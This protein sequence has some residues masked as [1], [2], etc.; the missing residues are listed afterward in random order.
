[1]YTIDASGF[2]TATEAHELD[3]AVSRQLLGVRYRRRIP[4]IVPTLV[5]VEVAGTISRLRGATH[6]H[7]IRTGALSDATAVGSA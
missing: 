7:R 3:F 4:L 5:I 2:V 1:M 6:A